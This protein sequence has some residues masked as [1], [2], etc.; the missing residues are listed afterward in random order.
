MR[1]YNSDWSFVEDEILT[2]FS[3]YSSSLVGNIS[4]A[5]DFISYAQHFGLPTRLVDWTRNPLVALF[6][7]MYYSD[8]ADNDSPRILCL[9]NL[10]TM[11]VYEPIHSINDGENS[12]HYNNPI[13]DYTLFVRQIQAGNLPKVIID[14][15]PVLY[16]IKD[17]SRQYAQKIHDKE[18]AKQMIMLN[19]GYSNARLLAQDGLFYLPR[20]LDK[21]AID[22]EYSA[23]KVTCIPIDRSWRTD[24]LYTLEHLGITKYKLFFD[25]ASVTESIKEN[26]KSSIKSLEDGLNIGF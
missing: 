6:F 14:S 4:N 26:M 3:K 9:R 24:I 18:H 20:K 5:F 21:V 8:R 22:Q 11:P 12:F 10:Y 23:S 16:G 25:L 7:A 17:E 13:H 1:C 19:S 2:E 15:A